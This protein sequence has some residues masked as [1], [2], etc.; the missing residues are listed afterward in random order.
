MGRY[1]EIVIEGEVGSVKIVTSHGV[2]PA[3][4]SK[5]S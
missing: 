3:A 2:T 5:G 4:I 1:R